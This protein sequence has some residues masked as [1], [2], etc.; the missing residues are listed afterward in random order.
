MTAVLAIALAL[1]QGTK[2]DYD[3]AAE[4]PRSLRGKG[5]NV[6]IKPAWS[7]DGNSF[8]YKRANGEF[9]Q[10]DAETGAKRIVADPGKPPDPPKKAPPPAESPRSSEQSPDGRWTVALKENNLALKSKEGGEETALTKDGTADD[11]YSPRVF[12]SPDSKHFVAMRTRKVEERVVTLVESSP[13][14]QLQPNVQTMRYAKPG[15]PLAVVKPHLFDAEKRA[16]IAVS[17][18]LF[19]TQWSLDHV[20][21]DRDSK[22]F[23]FLYNQRGHQALRIVAVAAESGE[24]RA[25]VNEESK[26]FIDYAH[27]QFTRWLGDDELLWMSERDGWCHLYLYD[28]RT[29]T[30]KNQVTKGEWVVRGVDRVDEAKR[31]I[32]F[33]AGGIIPGQDPYHV[34]FARINLD[35]TG[36]ALLTE[37]DGTHSIEYSPDG[38]YLIDTYSRVDLAPVT[39]LR[40]VSDGKLI[41]ALERGDLAALVAAGWKAPER[42]VSKGRDGTTDIHGVIHRPTNFDASKKYPVIESIYAGPQGSFVPKSFREFHP[43]QALAE[44]GFVVV[45]IDGMGTSNRSKAFHDVCWHNLGDSGF[46]DRI[47]WMKAAAATRPFMDLA[48]VG[49]FGGSAGG[50]S[51][52]RALLAHGDFYNAAVADCGCHDNRMDKVWWNEL[53]MGWPIGPHYAEQSNVTQAH[54]LQGKLLLIVAE[55]DKNV[56]PSSTMQVVNALI[57]ADKD[58]DLLVVPGAGHGIGGGPYGTRRRN[59]FFVRNLLGVEPRRP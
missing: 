25:I 9:V 58:F 50:Q 8:T 29:G 15:D 26:T 56:D 52:L 27:K 42:F 21:W 4:L 13:K 23:T 35:G 34:H 40:R 37:G 16:E 6:E 30:V 2:A 22:R 5:S 53:W 3:R 51:A 20:R 7:A 49:I 43:A 10:V 31:E 33:H 48:R 1:V 46:P 45:Q 11:G 38:R 28:A 32:W 12:W 36:L 24:A 54:K 14:N 19:P 18:A 59:D 57:K 39:E 41:C 17:D 55:L 44:L 47:P